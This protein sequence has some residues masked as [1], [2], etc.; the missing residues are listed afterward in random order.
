MINFFSIS[1]VCI[2]FKSNLKMH[3]NKEMLRLLLCAIFILVSSHTFSV[4]PPVIDGR[5]LGL[6]FKEGNECGAF[7]QC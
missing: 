2:V 4:P 3:C 6:S 7:S 1:A 5:L